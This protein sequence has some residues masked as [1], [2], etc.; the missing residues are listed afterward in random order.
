LAVAVTGTPSLATAHRSA[1]KLD[2]AFSKDGKLT[3]SFPEPVALAEDLALQDDGKIIVA[4]SAG[5]SVGT[6]YLRPSSFAMVR[7]RKNGRIDRSFGERGRML[8]SFGGGAYGNAVATQ[9][10]GKLIVTG[11]VL[12]GSPASSD[13][14]QINFALARFDREGRLDTTFGDNGLVSY[15]IAQQVGLAPDLDQGRDVAVQADGKIV[16]AADA[17]DRGGFALRFQ[18]DGSPDPTFSNDGIVEGPASSYRSIA[19]QADGALLLAGR[20]SN[21]PNADLALAR[22]D[23]N[24][25]LDSSFAGNGLVTT[26]VA[27][28]VQEV[29]EQVAIASDGRILLLGTSCQFGGCAVD[30]VRYTIDGALDPS[31]SNGGL[32]SLPGDAD[33]PSVMTLNGAQPIVASESN[34]VVLRR[35]KQDGTLDRSFSRDGKAV[36]KFGLA[37][38]P[39]GLAV[40]SKGRLV[41][42]GTFSTDR[43]RGFALARYLLR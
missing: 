23:S 4:G 8:A 42:A 6:P 7:Y 11:W 17:A 21:L 24:G 2:P 25:E 10:D 31:L 19:V 36:S 35:F 43:P 41:M 27:G 16:V 9:P 3:T 29:A 13:T 20:Y 26:D 34:G 5:D 37:V 33:H 15:D 22:L 32:L 12:N 39:A 18:P 40:T 1:G 30:L 28:A 38:S 14:N